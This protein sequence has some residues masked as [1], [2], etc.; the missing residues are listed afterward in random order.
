MLCLYSLILSFLK[1][2]KYV[3]IYQVSIIF[4]QFIVKRKKQHQDLHMSSSS[5]YS[6]GLR[7]SILLCINYSTCSIQYQGLGFEHES[8]EMLFLNIISFLLTFK[9]IQLYNQSKL[10]FMN[11]IKID[12]CYQRLYLFFFCFMLLMIESHA[13]NGKIF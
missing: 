11:R 3:F 10:N 12:C 6:H 7:Y 9:T 4:Y 13:M 8:L 1:Q 2:M 5:Y